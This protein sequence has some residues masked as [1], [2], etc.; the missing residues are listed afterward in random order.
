MKF[1]QFYQSAA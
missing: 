1:R